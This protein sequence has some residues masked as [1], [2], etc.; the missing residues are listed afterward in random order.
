MTTEAEAEVRVVRPDEAYL[1]MVRTFNMCI[2]AKP[3]K[4]LRI[5]L[6]KEEA[7][8][9]VD[10]VK[11]KDLVE[12]I[13][14]LCDL[15]YV[16]YGAAAVFGISVYNENAAKTA[17]SGK[18]PR[19]PDLEDE[20]DSFW[21]SIGWATDAI[22]SGDRARMKKEL[23]DLAEGCW[24]CGAEGLGVDLRPFFL[25]VHRTNMHKLNG[26]RRDDGKQLK[27][28]GWMPPR[29]PYMLERVQEGKN[30]VCQ[31]IAPVYKDGHP[32][33]K[34]SIR[35]HPSGGMYCTTCGGVFVQPEFNQVENE[36]RAELI[37]G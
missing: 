3:D 35:L 2:D 29:I 18:D 1:H 27:P 31:V 20:L 15:L 37:K 9:F 26:P 25:E 23:H 22:R 36:R 5:R 34:E 11:T 19:W 4:E 32:F 8:E 17:V 28:E 13:D 6:I 33:C 14:A 30:P 21:E 24:V 12:A 16:T 7:Q 10:A